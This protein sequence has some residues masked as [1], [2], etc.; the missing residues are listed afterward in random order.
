MVAIWDITRAPIRLITKDTL[1]V[2]VRGGG[3]HA[4][5]RAIRPKVYPQREP[6]PVARPSALID[7]RPP[8]LE[9]GATMSDFAING[10][11]T[12][13]FFLSG[14]IDMSSAPLVDTALVPAIAQAG[15]VTLIF[16]T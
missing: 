6:I 5:R 8:T 11:G 2:G 7:W 10:D 1:C 15:P 3:G 13:T 14:E 16:R 12:R 4:A 9:K